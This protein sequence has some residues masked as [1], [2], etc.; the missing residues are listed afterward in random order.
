MGLRGRPL[1]GVLAGVVVA[2]CAVPAAR[3]AEPVPFATLNGRCDPLLHDQLFS[4]DPVGSAHAGVIR[5]LTAR[6]GDVELNDNALS[7]GD[8]VWDVGGTLG[9]G[10]SPSVF[11]SCLGAPD[12]PS[13]SVDFFDRPS[14]P[15]SFS[16]VGNAT[17]SVLGFAALG[18]A[19]YVADV[20]RDKGTVGLWSFESGVV[21]QDFVTAGRLPLGTV[22]SGDHELFLATDDQQPAWTVTIRALP[23]AVTRVGFDAPAARPGTPLDAHFTTDGDTTVTA[24]VRDARRRIVATPAAGVRVSPGAHPL[25]WL[26]RDSDGDPLREGVYTLEISTRDPSGER[27]AARARVTLDGTPPTLRLTSRDRFG[28]HEPLTGTAFDD[29]SGVGAVTMVDADDPGSPI[30]PRIAGP[31]FSYVPAAG[32]RPG[33]H[34]VLVTATDVAG[35]RR[36]RTEVFTVRAA[37]R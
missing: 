22:E 24:V 1:A 30:E 33:P 36:E 6:T 16:G 3:A 34:R 21:G 5:R 17:G 12:A 31:W 4:A 20:E 19:Q 14:A 8:V 35:N 10:A 26:T 25:H 28:V 2:L 15:A 13:F 9:P 27:S 37:G 23:V 7:Q 18:A 29:R 11:G 32:W